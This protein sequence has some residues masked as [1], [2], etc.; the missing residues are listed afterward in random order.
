[1]LE[2]EIS[3]RHGAPAAFFFNDRPGSIVPWSSRNGRGS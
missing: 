1:M 2:P 3:E